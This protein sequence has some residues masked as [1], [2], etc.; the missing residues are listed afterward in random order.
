[1][2]DAGARSAA[3]LAP[4]TG[5]PDPYTEIRITTLHATR[6]MNFWS[7][8]PVTRLDL[9][10][11]AY[12]DLSSAELPGFVDSLLDALPGLREHECSIGRPGGFVIRLR[13]GTYVPHIVEHVALELQ[14]MIGHDVG[15]GRTRG[16]DVAGEYTIVFEHR[17]DQ[18][19]LRAAALALETVQRA[20]SGTLDRPHV[21]AAVAELAALARDPGTPAP[22]RHIVCAVTG[23]SGRGETV[24]RLRTL[25]R[26]PVGILAESKDIS[27][28]AERDDPLVIDVS[29][30][31]ILQA[32]L[33]Y[34]RSDAAV[35]LDAELVDVPERYREPEHARR[36]VSTVA[37]A[38]RRGGFVVCPAKAWEI[39]DYAREQ[40]CSIAIFATDDDVTR[41]DLKVASALAVVRDGRIALEH[42]GDPHDGGALLPDVPAAAQVAAA[43]AAYVLDRPCSARQPN[44]VA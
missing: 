15:F 20:I 34:A 3:S 38:V 1:M 40:D 18:V 23:G 33:P 14:T 17:H 13:R 26:E 28:P 24:A 9:R 43:L 12:D 41:R 10:V 30:A 25:V 4:G 16:G 36:L 44:E 6:G 27:A 7:V 35:I 31:F 2:G 21:D 19:G 42:C 39:Q 32:G 37:D 11:G 22:V 8:R 29:P 5:V